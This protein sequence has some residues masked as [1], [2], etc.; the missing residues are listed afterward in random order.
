MTT[1][2]ALL[3]VAEAAARLRKSE[4]AMRWLIHRGT[5]PRSGLIGGRRMFREED[6]EAFI[7]AAFADQQS[8]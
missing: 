7:E 2:S 8:A 6:V 1:G 3:T 4:K 5:A